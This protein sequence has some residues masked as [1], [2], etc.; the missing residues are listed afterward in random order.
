[1]LG[2]HIAGKTVLSSA[3][4]NHLGCINGTKTAFAF[5][6]YQE[7][8]SSALS[9]MHSLISQLVGNDQDLMA[10]VCESMSESLKNNLTTTSDLLASVIRC[11]GHVYLVL[12]GVD[13]MSRIERGQ[14][15][16]ELLPLA[17]TNAAM[18]IIFSAR[19]EADLMRLLDDT[20]V[21]INVHEQ[22]KRN[23][24]DY[25]DQRVKKMFHVRRVFPKARAVIIQLLKPLVNRAKG[26]FL[27]ARLIMDMVDTAHD[28]SEIE[29]ELAV[30]PENLDAA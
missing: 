16:T 27:Y 23:I 24:R 3:I 7:A 11:T 28:L 20:A 1:M 26:M 17:K 14:L 2:I 21:I 4:V 18:K 8:R 6:T 13:E 29:S 5:L 25:I 10:V 15:V 9:A 22:N 12:D 30:L 19:P